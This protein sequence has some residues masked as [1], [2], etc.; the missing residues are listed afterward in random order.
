MPSVDADKQFIQKIIFL[1]SWGGG[2]SLCLHLISWVITGHALHILEL[3]LWG[4]VHINTAY[5]AINFSITAAAIAYSLSLYSRIGWFVAVFL[6]SLQGLLFAVL[7]TYLI[8]DLWKMSHYSDV[9]SLGIS[10]IVE[11]LTL[12]ICL[13]ILV[14]S[15]ILYLSIP[16]VRAF[17]REN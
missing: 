17:F 8:S 5:P 1:L 12:N 4:S 16:A 14:I 3:P 9:G 2:I 10:P 7:T 15:S 6:L 13:L 11:S